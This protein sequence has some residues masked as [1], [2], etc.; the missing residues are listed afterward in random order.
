MTEP[1]A[2][3][4]AINHLARSIDK[5]ADQLET[6]FGHNITEVIERTFGSPAETS[7]GI[8]PAIDKLAESIADNQ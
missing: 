6:K 2:L 1:D 7:Y 5:L 3:A 8:V 4:D